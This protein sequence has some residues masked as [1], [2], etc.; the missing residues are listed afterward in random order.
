M[1]GA[2]PRRR[3]PRGAAERVRGLVVMLPWL[4]QRKRVKISDMAAQ[5]NISREDLVEDM[6]MAAMCGVPPYTPFELTE[7][8]IDDD[9]I[10]VG[11][12]RRFEQRLEL[13]AAEAFALSL[14]AVA[15]QDLPGFRRK[16]ELKNALSKLGNV[17]GNGLVDVDLADSEHL[18]MMSRA[19]ATGERIRIVYLTPA[20]GERKERTIVVRSVFADRG[21][22]YITADDDLSG[23]SRH[24]RL[25]R[26]ESAV[27]TGEFAQVSESVPQIP[28]WF[29]ESDG[30]IVATLEVASRVAWVAETYPCTVLSEHHD[31]SL[32]IRIVA[33]SEHWLGRLLLRAGDGVTVVDPPEMVDLRER[34]ARQVLDVYRSNSSGN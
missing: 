26:V 9:Y 34:A 5:F 32:T 29:S 1:S 2:N 7:L 20:S 14:M 30:K 28:D 13:S 3:G 8:I 19:A 31:G 15:A 22:W 33:N 11:L 6:L 21:H 27:E 17:L 16:R 10:E 25:D 4:M 18:D 23:Q 24:F 12:N